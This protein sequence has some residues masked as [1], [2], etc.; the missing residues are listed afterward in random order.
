M[1]KTIIQPH[2]TVTYTITANNTS[3][4]VWSGVQVSDTLDYSLMTLLN[5]SITVNGVKVSKEA[6]SFDGRR[7][8]LN[9]GDIQ[10]GQ[11]VRASFSV[12]FKAD[13]SGKTFAGRIFYETEKEHLRL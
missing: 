13:A 5:D 2:E 9:L 10:P 12:E 7:L 3:D 6:W 8:V 11:S 1:D 4:K